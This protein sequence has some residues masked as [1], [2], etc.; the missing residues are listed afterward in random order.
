MHIMIVI[1]NLFIQKK[2]NFK[3]FYLCNLFEMTFCCKCIFKLYR[4]ANNF[5]DKMRTKMLNVEP[6][7]IIK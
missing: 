5:L 1:H 3:Y 6:K 7:N 2:K 4:F